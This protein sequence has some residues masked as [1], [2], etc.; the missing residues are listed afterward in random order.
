MRLLKTTMI[1]LTIFLSSFFL[2]SFTIAIPQQSSD[3]ESDLK[4]CLAKAIAI[5]RQI[6]PDKKYSV[7][8]K[9]NSAVDYQSARYLIL[10]KRV[11]AKTNQF[12]ITNLPANINIRFEHEKHDGN[13][14]LKNINDDFEWKITCL[15]GRKYSV[16]MHYFIY[17]SLDHNGSVEFVFD[18]NT[19]D[20]TANVSVGKVD[21]ESD[22]YINTKMHIRNDVIISY[23]QK[24]TQ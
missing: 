9:L 15:P 24:R 2:Y 10:Q 3:I 4:Y 5:D 14:H 13:D 1:M 7:N 17:G 21:Q 8:R 11:A 20:Y 18:R 22:G 23:S 6:P 16:K 12:R 19:N